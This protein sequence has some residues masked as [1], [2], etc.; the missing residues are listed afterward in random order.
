MDVHP[1]HEPVHTWRDA[2]IHLGIVTVGLFIALTLEGI[3]EYVHHRDLVREAR[4]NIRQELQGNH[5]AIGENLA[6]IDRQS[7]MIQD[8]LAT[9]RAMEVDPRGHHSLS[10]AF[11]FSTLDDAAWQSAR[12]TGALGFMPYKEVQLDADLYQLQATANA[13]MTTI[14]RRGTDSFVPVVT[15]DNK[16]DLTPD[17]LHSMIRENGIGLIDLYTLKQFLQQLDTQYGQALRH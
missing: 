7:A 3:V 5:R 15:T 10:F 4:E 17:Q 16:A 6:S 2:F 14:V 12:D 13:Q 1:P 11:S 9:L 8:D